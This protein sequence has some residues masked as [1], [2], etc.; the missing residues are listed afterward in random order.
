LALLEVEA[1]PATLL[2]KEIAPHKGILADATYVVVGTMLV[3]GVGAAEL[4]GRATELEMECVDIE[5][6]VIAPATLE[7]AVATLES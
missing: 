5:L 4:I 7:C 6:V 1:R 3:A 2:T